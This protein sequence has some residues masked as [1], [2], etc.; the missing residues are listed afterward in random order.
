MKHF[1]GRRISRTFDSTQYKIPNSYTL[2]EIVVKSH[3]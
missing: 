1:Y 3:S 2:I